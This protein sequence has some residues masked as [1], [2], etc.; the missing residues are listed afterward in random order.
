MVVGP[1]EPGLRGGR[2]ARTADRIAG[3]VGVHGDQAALV[4]R[5]LALIQGDVLD[6]CILPRELCPRRLGG[7][8]ALHWLGRHVATPTIAWKILRPLTELGCRQPSRYVGE[9]RVYAEREQI[10]GRN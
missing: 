10:P 1:R 4:N 7:R 5:T 9:G 8:A 3:V 2:R 6:L